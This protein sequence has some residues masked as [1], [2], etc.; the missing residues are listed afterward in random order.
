MQRPENSSFEFAE[1]ATVTLGENRGEVPFGGLVTLDVADLAASLTISV[2]ASGRHYSCSLEVREV[3]E[4]T[5]LDA[6]LEC[7]DDQG[8]LGF[9]LKVT[10][11]MDLLDSLIETSEREL[12]Q[13]EEEMRRLSV[14]MQTEGSKASRGKKQTKSALAKR[15]GK[16]V[17]KT[18]NKSSSDSRPSSFAGLGGAAV[19]AMNSLMTHRAPVL[20][21]A[22]VATIYFV[23]DFASV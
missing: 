9:K 21:V 18:G 5:H 6:E 11:S 3:P 7:L 4:D 1:G 23:G 2:W 16:S 17:K 22:A 12:S 20:F 10:A 13:V 14:E 8:G 19:G 15:Q